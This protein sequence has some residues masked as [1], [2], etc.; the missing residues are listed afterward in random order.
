[1]DSFVDV[2]LPLP[3]KKTFTYFFDRKLF[4]NINSGIFGGEPDLLNLD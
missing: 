1:M 3:I 2:I 4:S